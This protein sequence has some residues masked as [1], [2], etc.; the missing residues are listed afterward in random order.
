MTGRVRR[1]EHGDNE[2]KKASDFIA[3]EKTSSR[4]FRALI[5]CAISSYST[6]RA[7]TSVYSSPSLT[8]FLACC[9]CDD[10]DKRMS[11]EVNEMR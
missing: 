6:F 9:V 1:K 3:R 11:E 7:S 4:L 2:E 10:D 5:R 8:P